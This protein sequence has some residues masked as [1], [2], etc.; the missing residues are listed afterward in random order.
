M[1][2]QFKHVGDLH[3]LDNNFHEPPPPM[4]AVLFYASNAKSPLS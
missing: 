2:F 1:V 3:C 4:I